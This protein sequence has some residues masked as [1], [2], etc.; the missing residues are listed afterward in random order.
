MYITS[1]VL[2]MTIA[3]CLVVYHVVISH[4]FGMDPNGPTIAKAKPST[5]HDPVPPVSSTR[6]GHRGHRLDDT[7]LTGVPQ[8]QIGTASITSVHRL[9][10]ISEWR[11]H[12]G[13]IQNMT[14]RGRECC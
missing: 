5:T 7:F 4:G 9:L 12:V 3:V 2:T 14:V 11:A 8:H 10:Q 6:H 13:A 1:I